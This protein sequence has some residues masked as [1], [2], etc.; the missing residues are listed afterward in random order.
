MHVNVSQVAYIM[1]YDNNV[2]RNHSRVI[3]ISEVAENPEIG[4]MDV[5]N[6]N[7]CFCFCFEKVCMYR[8]ALSWVIF[9]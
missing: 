7:P 8:E 2:Q 9:L 1:P 3:Q 4:D 6:W 5:A